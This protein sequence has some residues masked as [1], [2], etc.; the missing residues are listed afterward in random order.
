MLMAPWRR[1]GGKPEL[2]S[3]AVYWICGKSSFRSS[4][5]RPELK[6]MVIFGLSCGM[7]AWLIRNTR[8][9]PGMNRS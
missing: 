4:A 7:I 5:S 1:V 8:S 9:C 2:L 3:L 6:S